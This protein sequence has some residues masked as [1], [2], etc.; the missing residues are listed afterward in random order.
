MTTTVLS[1]PG[2]TRLLISL[3]FAVRLLRREWRSG[4]LGM[5]GVA[6]IVAVSSIPPSGS[7][8]DRVARG[9][10]RG[11]GKLLAADLI[12]HS[13]QPIAER[14]A[15]AAR[16]QRLATTRLMM[17]RSVLLVDGNFNSVKSKRS[18]A[19]IRCAAC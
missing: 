16:E 7:L 4:E 5:L 2:A 9:M 10:E 8:T 14:Y 18:K 3:R 13:P 19:V 1:A 15:R 11:A 6:I 17:F 12:I